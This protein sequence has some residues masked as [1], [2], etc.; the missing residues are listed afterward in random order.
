MLIKDL[1]SVAYSTHGD[2]QMAVLYDYNAQ[3]VV[4]SG[5]IDYIIKE[6]GSLTLHRLQAYKD[7]LVLEVRM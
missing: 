1:K 2:I 4:A 7:D 5:S 6:Y 3:R